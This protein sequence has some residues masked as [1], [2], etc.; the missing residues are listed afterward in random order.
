MFTRSA[1]AVLSLCALAA[2]ESAVAQ[3]GPGL[4]VPATA[5]QIASWDLDINPSGAGL[6]AGSGTAAAGK[7]V[8]EQKCLACHGKE[9]AG[10]PNDQLVGGHGTI[11]SA[12]PVRTVGSY[13]PYATTLFDYIR[14]AMPLVQPQSLSNDE[15]YALTAYLLYLNDII[16]EN[17]TMN[18][19]T[20]PK[21]VM[22][23][24]DAFV[25]AYPQRRE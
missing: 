16:E 14:R 5:E 4:G 18:A 9:G 22:P 19:T 7:A 10:Q 17:D 25:V 6:P 23:N 2:L 12:A 1:L 11:K 15:I 20:L 21:V 13:W 24:R 8:Y 3:E